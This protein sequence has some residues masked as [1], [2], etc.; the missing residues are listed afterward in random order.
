MSRPAKETLPE[1]Q[2]VG[3]FRSRTLLEVVGIDEEGESKTVRA[4]V[5][6]WDNEQEISFPFDSVPE[7]LRE[8]LKPASTFLVEV[9]LAAD[10]VA[11]LRPS[12]FE[13]APPP[14]DESDL[15]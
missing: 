3:V 11:E 6:G 9:N 5:S 2:E 7:V 13:L 1:P 4:I 8:Y 14:V 10:S 12:G 15:S